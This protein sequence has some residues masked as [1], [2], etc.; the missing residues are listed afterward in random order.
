MAM[1]IFTKKGQSLVEVVVALGILAI[2]FSGTTGLLV[3]VVNL[4]LNARDIT[5][6][7]G[8]A[9]EGIT[10]TLRGI[11]AQC[12][13]SLPAGIDEWRDAPNGNRFHLVVTSGFVDIPDSGGAPTSG[14]S[15]I[16]V[17]STVSWVDPEG[18]AFPPYTVEEVIRRG[19]E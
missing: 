4:N 5:Q 15:F 8:L 7:T 18:N 3:R 1:L 16:R 6:A 13:A 11:R 2:V 10:R 14:S 19:N 9:Q 17:R 12:N